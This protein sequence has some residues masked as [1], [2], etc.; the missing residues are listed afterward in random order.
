MAGV[1]LR[2]V[3]E[4]VRRWLLGEAI[5][6]D[7]KSLRGSRRE[8]PALSVVVAAG[9]KVQLVLA[10]EEVKGE[11]VIE[12]AL[13]LIQ[14]LPLEGRV[15]TLDAGLNQREIALGVVK[16]NHARLREILLQDL[17]A[18]KGA[19]LK[20]RNRR[21][22]RVEHREYWWVEADQEMRMYL[23]REL[24]WPQVRWYG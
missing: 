18:R 16:D 8:L 23:E 9:Q 11:N 17:L 7:A 13:R 3:E 10:Q 4:A 14:G 12:A 20:Q 22:G 5:S 1:E 2:H 21:H 15:V 19:S 24:G 6:V